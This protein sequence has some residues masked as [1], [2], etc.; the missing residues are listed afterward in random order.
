MSEGD[1]H[2]GDTVQ[3]ALV[4]IFVFVP[5]C[6]NPHWFPLLLPGVLSH[7]FPSFSYSH[8]T[9]CICDAHTMYF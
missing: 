5:S 4:R 2:S 6:T 1:I 9:R 3:N 7:N 8:T